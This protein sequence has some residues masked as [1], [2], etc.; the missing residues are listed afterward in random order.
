VYAVKV[1]SPTLHPQVGIGVKLACCFAPGYGKE[2]HGTDKRK[3]K[4]HTCPEPTEQKQRAPD[5]YN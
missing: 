5:N 2:Q 4:C 1:H 3:A